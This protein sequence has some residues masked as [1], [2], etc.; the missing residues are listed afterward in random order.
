M[1]MAGGIPIPLKNMSSSIGMM[2]F[3][4]EW[5]KKHVPNHQP[6]GLLGE[7]SPNSHDLIL[8]RY[9]SN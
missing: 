5:G 6:D 7:Y 3:P 2:T 1:D 4:T 8:Q 9:L